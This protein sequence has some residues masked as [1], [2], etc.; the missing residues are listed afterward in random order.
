MAYDREAFKLRGENARLNFPERFLKKTKNESVSGQ[1]SSSSSPPTPSLK[2]D[3][4]IKEKPKESEEIVTE[5][6]GVHGD[7]VTGEENSDPA[8]GEMAE[9][10]YN[11]GWGPGSAMWDS[12]DTNN[13]LIFP[14]D[15]NLENHDEHQ[16]QHEQ[17]NYDFSD[18]ESQMNPFFWKDE[19]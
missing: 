5:S 3:D 13:S 12:L 11:S 18:F 7:P 8:W 2:E 9:N 15:Y 4:A 1:G 6:E 14:S 16:N 19:A 17:G 10:W